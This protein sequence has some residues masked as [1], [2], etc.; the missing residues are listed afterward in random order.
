MPSKCR[1]QKRALEPLLLGLQMVVS[2]HVANGNW[3]QP[4]VLCRSSKWP[5]SHRS[6]HLL[7]GSFCK[8]WSSVKLE[9]SPCK[10]FYARDGVR[11]PSRSRIK[12]SGHASSHYWH[13]PGSDLKIRSIA[14]GLNSVVLCLSPPY[15]GIIDVG[16]HFSY[17]DSTSIMTIFSSLKK[18]S[19]GI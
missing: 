10:E 2:R 13:C 3:K 14:L 9:G 12:R 8:F 15:D 7:L 18:C 17:R 19:I 11:L 1:G 4:W 6:G 16:Y 5:L